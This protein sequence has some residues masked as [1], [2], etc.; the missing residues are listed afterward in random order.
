MAVSRRNIVALVLGAAAFGAGAQPPPAASRPG[1]V[2][3]FESDSF[4]LNRSANT[5]TF[6]GFRI[7]G[8]NWNL[9]ADAAVANAEELDFES[10]QWRFDGNIALQL[11]TASLE[12]E[13]AVFVFRGKRLVQA[14]LTGNPVTFRDRTASENDAAEG[15]AMTLRYDDAAQT[16]ELLGNVSLT[17]GPYL[18]TG[19]DLVYYLGQ[20]EFK[21]GS[22]QCD[23]PFRTI[24][25]PQ[26]SAETTAE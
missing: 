7:F 17:V 26:E 23:E 8:E 2:Q 9:T 14:E 24:I 10:G 4:D 6:N 12:A 3:E 25:V 18:T 22:T 15:S 19:C 5:M 21:T 13:S 1:A 11:D 20:E 16:F